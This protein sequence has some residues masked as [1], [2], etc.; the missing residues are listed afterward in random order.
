MYPNL[1]SCSGGKEIKTTT[2]Q[3]IN[4]SINQTVNHAVKQ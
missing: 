4:Q 3:S 1:K 2:N